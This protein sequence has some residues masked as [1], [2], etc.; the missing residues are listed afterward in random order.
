M[1]MVRLPDGGARYLMLV[2]AQGEEV[3]QRLLDRIA[4][5]VTVTGSVERI[6]DLWILKASPDSIVRTSTI[7]EDHGPS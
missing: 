2:G 5:P 1:L 7:R 3:G 4:E 6:L